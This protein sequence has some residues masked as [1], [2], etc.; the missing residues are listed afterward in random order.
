MRKAKKES[1]GGEK[2][3]LPSTKAM[4]APTRKSKRVTRKPAKLESTGLD[5]GK[6]KKLKQVNVGQEVDGDN[7]VGQQPEQVANG[8]GEGGGSN[9]SEANDIEFGD[10]SVSGS[11]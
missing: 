9:G 4:E 10:E 11:N 1:R 2:N 6:E 3:P 5:E 7:D 8:D